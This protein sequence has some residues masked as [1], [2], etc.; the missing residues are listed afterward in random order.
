MLILR[1]MPDPRRLEPLPRNE[2][3]RRAFY[4]RWGHEH[5]I[6]LARA[7]WV[8]LQAQPKTDVETAEASA[9][10]DIARA[11]VVEEARGRGADPK[12]MLAALE[13]TLRLDTR[14]NQELHRRVRTWFVQGQVSEEPEAFTRKVYAE[15]F[16]SPLDDPWAG[17]APAEAFAALPAAG[18]RP[19]R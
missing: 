14:Q 11:F 15:L 16:L 10:S 12:A 4:S 9:L 19:S 5:C 8:P 6:V 18:L 13:R 2:A 17:L 7:G 3:Y 1:Q